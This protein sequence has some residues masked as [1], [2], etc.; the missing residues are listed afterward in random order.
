M[1]KLASG[2]CELHCFCSWQLGLNLQGVPAEHVLKEVSSYDTVGNAYFS[3]VIHAL[4]ADWRYASSKMSLQ[5]FY[6]MMVKDGKP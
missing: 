3:L 6:I 4:P 1:A 2:C 5:I